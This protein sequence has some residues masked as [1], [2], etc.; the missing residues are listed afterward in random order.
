MDGGELLE[1]GAGA[2][3]FLSEAKRLGFNPHAIELNP[4]QAQFIRNRFAIPCEEVEFS[5]QSFDGSTFDIVYHCDVL[6]HFYDP[7]D[8][9][10]TI[11]EKLNPGGILVFE[12]GNLADVTEEFLSYVPSYQYP[13]H[14]FFFGETNIKDLLKR[15]GFD[16]RKMLRYSIMPQYKAIQTKQWFGRI[17]RKRT[18]EFEVDENDAGNSAMSPSLPRKG[19]RKQLNI[20]WR[21]SE[22]LARYRIGRIALKRNRPQTVIVVAQRL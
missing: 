13:D 20:A 9:F 12:T 17:W 10:C 3:Y 15:T 7:I 21:Y 5:L 18:S 1:I 2:G 8:A 14:L 11:H 19:F 16:I 4:V 6:S 22:Y